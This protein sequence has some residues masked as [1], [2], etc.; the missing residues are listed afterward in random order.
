MLA[1]LLIVRF[2]VFCKWAP[3]STLDF[4][5][6]FNV[7]LALLHHC[8]R[9]EAC[10]LEQLCCLLLVQKNCHRIRGTELR[11]MQL[12]VAVVAGLL[13]RVVL[14]TTYKQ[15]STREAG[16]RCLLDMLI[17]IIQAMGQDSGPQAVIWT[18][19]FFPIMAQS[20][21]GKVKV[22]RALIKHSPEQA[23]HP[24]Q[25]TGER[26]QKVTQVP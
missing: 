4:F 18:N 5:F 8:Q 10:M 16:R 24:Q 7:S 21:A 6:L 13:A 23:G 19:W 3:L 17:L 2:F 20:M 9:T 11:L 15:Y 22:G 12:T 25:A 14:M 26:T 1:F